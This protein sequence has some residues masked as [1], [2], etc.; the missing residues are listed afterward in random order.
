MTEKKIVIA[1]DFS[2][3][4][5]GR[6]RT[7]SDTSG[8]EF[9]EDYLAP[10]L[11]AYTKVI[12]DLDGTD[13]Y[14]SSFLEEA[15]GGLIREEGFTEKDLKKKLIIISGRRSYSI[16]IWQY[17]EDEQGRRQGGGIA[18]LVMA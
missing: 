1:N 17:I 7:D 11:K 5:I 15:F 12:V 14:G 8:Q 18:R 16:R 4:P 3:S 6:Y 2:P 9:R 13:G 10:A